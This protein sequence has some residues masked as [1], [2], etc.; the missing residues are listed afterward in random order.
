[1]SGTLHHVELWVP[2]IDRAV[3]TVGRLLEALGHT[4]FQSWEA[5][6]S[7]RLGTTYLVLEQSPAL[8]AGRH[9]RHRP[10][11]NHLAFH[12]EDD[13]EVDRL[14]ADAVRHGWRL[15]FQDRHPYAGGPRHYAAYLEN[16]DGFEVELVAADG[17]RRDPPGVDAGAAGR[18]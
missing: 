8:T 7:W 15:M 10:G 11:L 16:E 18:T 6:R 9:D 3:A 5:G 2:D 12:V 17:P 14:A 4:P 1:M 13:A